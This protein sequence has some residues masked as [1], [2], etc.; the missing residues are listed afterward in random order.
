MFKR[1]A[2]VAEEFAGDEILTRASSMAYYTALAIAPLIVL[3]VWTLA[4]VNP[5]LQSELVQNVSRFVGDEGAKLIATIIS[6]AE[7]RPDLTSMSGW[8]ALAGL[9][10]SASVIFAQ[11]QETLNI[12]FDVE[13]VKKN[14]S[15]GLW[16][17]TKHL[18]FARLFS[19]GMLLTFVF[20]AIVSL[21]FSSL[22]AFFLRGTAAGTFEALLFAFNF[23]VFALL[24]AVLFK[25]MPDRHVS[26]KN[27]LYGGLITSLLFLLG[28]SAIGFYLARA[29]VGSA[30]GAAGSLAVLLVWVF[31][32]AVIFFLGAEVAYTFL[33]SDRENNPKL[34]AYPAP[35]EA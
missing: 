5:G 18:L 19:V 29:A 22:I 9:I 23:I 13:S 32:S 15:T 1:L 12:I 24:F 30:Y 27:A 8:L 20:L 7:D 34:A 10:I 26:F 28:K 3:V 16:A 11:L 21:I 31:Y 35:P 33:V 25:W 6:G 4:V 2:L 17:A 14:E